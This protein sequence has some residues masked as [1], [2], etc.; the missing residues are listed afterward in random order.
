[1]SSDPHRTPQ[2]PRGNA[3]TI[4]SEPLV[5]LVLLALQDTGTQSLTGSAVLAS[6]FPSLGPSWPSAQGRGLLRWALRTAAPP[7]LTS[8]STLRPSCSEC[9]LQVGGCGVTLVVAQLYR[10]RTRIQPGRPQP[11]SVHAAC[12]K[13]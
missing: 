1:M 12:G 13:P 7:V 4:P 10:I 11:I 9:A 8:K 5:T 6:L 2:S 3:L